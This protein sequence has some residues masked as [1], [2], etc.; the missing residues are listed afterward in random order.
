MLQPVLGWSAG[1]SSTQGWQQVAATT[2]L[3]GNAIFLFFLQAVF[4]T[5]SAY[6]MWGHAICIKYGDSQLCQPTMNELGRHLQ[7]LTH[8]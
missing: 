1:L 6:Y 4:P 7:K 2:Q 8:F 3:R 5:H